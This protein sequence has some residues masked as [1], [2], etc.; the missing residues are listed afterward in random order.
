MK[1]PICDYETYSETNRHI[2][3]V[4]RHEVWQK[5]IGSKIKTRHFDYYIKNTRPV[6]SSHLTRTWSNKKLT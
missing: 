3:Q 2:V 1:C 4:A 5:A 6:K